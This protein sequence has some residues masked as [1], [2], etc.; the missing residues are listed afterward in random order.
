M[1][2]YSVKCRTCDKAEIVEIEEEEAN[3]ILDMGRDLAAYAQTK[4]SECHA[5]Y[6]RR[7]AAERPGVTDDALTA[8]GLIQGYLA[9]DAAKGNNHLL[10]F[11]RAYGGS[12]SLFIGGSTGLGKS[13]S[14]TVA[15]YERLVRQQDRRVRYCFFPEMASLY[16][17]LYSVSTMEPVVFLDKL[18]SADLLILDDVGNETLTERVADGLFQLVDRRIRENRRVWVTTQLDGD[19][20]TERVGY[21]GGALLRRLREMCLPYTV[22]EERTA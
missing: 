21:R 6:A 20:L 22:S 7:M 1:R 17:G 12:H 9:W 13:R 8:S 15:A 19:G 4:G 11:V 3:T 2:R 18:G 10:S 14:V 5:C 16:A